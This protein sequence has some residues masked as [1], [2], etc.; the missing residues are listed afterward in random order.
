MMEEEFANI[1]LENGLLHDSISP[2]QHQQDVEFDSK[3]K[4]CVYYFDF[5]HNDDDE[6]LRN[7]LL[8]FA[9]TDECDNQ[10]AE[11]TNYF[12]NFD[13]DYDLEIGDGQSCEFCGS[14]TSD[15][16]SSQVWF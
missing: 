1:S 5:L 15:G 14:Q 12:N 6:V 7:N 8:V 13:T 9:N 10:S 11:L 16:S 3:T 4:Y 2:K